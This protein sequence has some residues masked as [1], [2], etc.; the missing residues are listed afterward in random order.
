MG[1][2]G[3]ELDAC[4][5]ALFVLKSLGLCTAS[6]GTRIVVTGSMVI[7]RLTTRIVVPQCEISA[8]LVVSPVR[9]SSNRSRLRSEI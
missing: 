7:I 3:Y 5:L 6:G 2:V 1:W 4:H 8:P 9:S